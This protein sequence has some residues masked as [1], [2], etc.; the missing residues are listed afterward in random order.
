MKERKRSEIVISRGGTGLYPPVPITEGSK[1]TFSLMSED[2]IELVFSLDEPVRYRIGDY[3]D[4]EV[5]G[6]FV[7]RSEQ[8]PRYNKSTGGYDYTLLFEAEHYLG[9]DRI[10]ML[11]STEGKRTEVTWSL[12]APLD[13]HA[14]ELINNFN[15]VK[16][17]T[18]RW[19]YV[20]EPSCE[21]GGESKYISYNNTHLISALNALADTFGCEWW[22]THEGNE[23]IIHFGKC[24]LDN[25]PLDFELG[26]NVED[27]EISDNLNSY[28][29]RLYMLGGTKNISASYGKKLLLT[30]ENV[31][32][33]KVTAT[34][35]I[36]A[37]QGMLTDEGHAS[38]GSTLSFE[39]LT[40]SQRGAFWELSAYTGDALVGTN[41]ADVSWKDV[42]AEFF[43]TMTGRS[44][45][46]ITVEF[47]L[48][49]VC[50]SDSSEVTLD[51]STM[52]RNVGTGLEKFSMSL[53]DSSYNRTV[54]GK[55]YRLKMSMLIGT[56]R[57]QLTFA[58]DD[59]NNSGVMF[60]GTGTAYSARVVF[61]GTEHDVTFNP[62]YETDGT[63]LSHRFAFDNGTP[64]GFTAGSVC[65]LLDYNPINIPDTYYTAESEDPSN[66]L[67]IGERRLHL[68]KELCP[69]GYLQ[70][71]DTLTE[72]Q[73]VEETI[74]VE[75]IYPKLH[76]RVTEVTE[77]TE[78]EREELTDGSVNIWYWQKY[79]VKLE[80]IDG[81]TFP[82]LHKYK[83]KDEKLDIIFLSEMDAE[84][85][86]R[87][88]SLPVPQS[89]GD[90][91]LAGMT[92]ECEFSDNAKTYT[93]FRNEDYGAKLPNG[94][95]K[96]TVGDVCVLTGWDVNAMSDLGLIEKAEDQLW[97]TAAAYHDALEEGQFTFTCHMMSDWP[98]SFIEGVPLYEANG[99]PFY[100][101]SG[102]EFWVKNDGSIYW[103]PPEG[104]KV[105]IIHGALKP[106]EDDIPCKVSRIIGY[107]LKL[108]KPWDS[109]VYTVGETE[110]FSRIKKIEKELNITKV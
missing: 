21:H 78:K 82:F 54:G 61:N 99:L 86:Y 63:E 4:D 59:Y 1:R 14:T 46:K 60:I 95:L 77:T 16:F 47:K 80:D 71:D 3:I 44:S 20:I 37:E 35:V 18:Q 73:I 22:V 17:I 107:E 89:V 8:M 83:A 48:L 41:G 106:D 88:R 24:E 28:A 9:E 25:E 30:A 66:I 6:T 104:T 10:F 90:C 12:T 103:L 85:A 38:P 31:S 45:D 81:S 92:F 75:D 79:V 53:P 91:L 70:I 51:S 5:F 52:W 42:S 110:A 13:T 56:D 27:M 58:E 40:L 98:S 32:G 109:P 19:R 108:D 11:L 26:V 101:G 15:E 65:E 74:I 64:S 34:P 57:G 23:G 84:K 7:L 97:D 50:T 67:S 33:G 39:H 105:R 2:S 55:R 87:E 62:D 49:L 100:E 94:V 69:E 43:A 68:P 96:P 76:L 36:R 93:I 102:K 72:E 29:N